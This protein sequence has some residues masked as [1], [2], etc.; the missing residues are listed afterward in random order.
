MKKLSLLVW[1]AFVGGSGVFGASMLNAQSKPPD[2]VVDPSWPRPFPD[3]WATGGIGGV[4]IDSQDHVFIVNRGDLTGNELDAAQVAPAFIELD[5]AGNVINSWGDPKTLPDEA[6]GCSIDRDGNLWVA[7]GQDSIVQK[8]SSGGKL[9]LQIG[10]K[11]A[12]DSSDGT[13]KGKALNSSHTGFYYSA[14]V[15]VDPGNG[16]LYIADGHAE[17]GNHRVAVF[18]HD[19]HFLRQWELH[20][21]PGD[22]SVPVLHCIAMSKD[23]RLYVCDRRG[24]RIQVF[25]KMGKFQQDIP[26]KFER[27]SQS[28][29]PS[30]HQV[31]TA[32]AVAFSR[33]DAQRFLY[34]ANQDDEQIEVVDR[35]S[36]KVLSTFS[37]A[38]EQ[39]G[40]LT[41]IHQVAVD[42]K[43]N[44]YTGEVRPGKRVQRFRPVKA[45]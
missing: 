44:I 20:R 21:A 38:G 43:G 2:F 30:E 1:L 34:V 37:R 31:G 7:G 13:N 33:D 42:S 19:A 45:D 4:C 15:A 6:M 39:A 40:E 5:A 16:D 18:D 3:H 28:A 29:P 27:R 12:F 25:D 24:D 35:S 10:K 26:I 8:Y 11:G 9:L 22:T 23:G 36:G 14:G 17:G 41:Y 32:V